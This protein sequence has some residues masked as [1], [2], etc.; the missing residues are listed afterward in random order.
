MFKI[1]NEG[2][3][4]RLLRIILSELFFLLAFFW[5]G[6][7]WQI[8]LY[9]LGTVSLLT[10]VT[11]F[12]GVYKI[13]GWSTNKD[14][15]GT[16]S[17][18]WK[19]GFLTLFIAVAILGGYYSNFFTKKFFLED[20]SR[21]NQYYKQTLFQTGQGNRQESVS[22]YENLVVEFGNF[23]KKYLN[24]HPYA[25]YGDSKFNSDLLTINNII[26][27]LKEGVYSGELVLI[28][29]DFEAIRP[30]FQDILKRNNFSMLA[31]YLVDFHDI[32][33]KIIDVADKKDAAGVIAVYP[34]VDN[35]LRVVEAEANDPEIMAIR[36]NLENLLA[37][38]KNGEAEALSKKAADLK[39]SFI[40]VY[41]KRG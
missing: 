27:G 41:L 24:Y 29:K 12:C 40:K 13:F 10:A 19:V 11:G 25:I 4:D 3:A 34:E 9:I 2:T 16:L 22:N 8:V 1:K 38:A 28:H 6:G 35:S 33:E 5:L 17:I 26:L 37:S 23:Y 36:Q 30:I 18:Y 7:V 39:S 14:P 15:E 32:M 31:V 21:M 20:Y